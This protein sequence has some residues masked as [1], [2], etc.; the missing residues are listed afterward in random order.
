MVGA[1]CFGVKV[2]SAAKGDGAAAGAAGA[3]TGFSA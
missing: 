2:G 3:S 1:V